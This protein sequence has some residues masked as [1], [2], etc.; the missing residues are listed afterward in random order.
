M[1]GG[2]AFCSSFA[3]LGGF[4]GRSAKGLTSGR[5]DVRSIL[6]ILNTFVKLFN[7][8]FLTNSFIRQ[9]PAP[10]VFPPVRFL[11]MKF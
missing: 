7:Q 3:S 11:R 4:T 6:D 9:V 1:G 5:F 2:G 10:L 8:N